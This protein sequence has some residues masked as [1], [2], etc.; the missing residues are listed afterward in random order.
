MT[1]MEMALTIAQKVLEA[2]GQSY[3]VGGYVRDL[4]MGID[5]KD[6]DLEI[7][8]VLPEK[9]AE[10]LDGLGERI[11]IGSS[12]GVYGLKGYGLD[13]AMPRKERATGRGHKD[14]EV[15]VDPFLGTEKAAQRRDF[16][17]NALMR[18]VLTGEIVD[19]FS[20]LSD[21]KE[22]LIRHV[23][24]ETFV[25]DPLRLYRGA[26]FAARFRFRIVPETR[27]LC[28]KMDVSALAGERVFDEMKKALL[29]ADTP[30]V[31]FEEIRKM[32]QLS[33]W[34]PEVGQMIGVEQNPE[35][36]QEGDVWTHTMLV[37]DE[38]ARR[39]ASVRQPL[40][41]MLAAL[42]HDFGK[43]VAT[44]RIDGRLCAYDH[45]H[46]GLPL[47]SSFLNR[48]TSEKQIIDYVMN[49]V[50]L[51]MKPHAMARDNAGIKKTNRMFD[52][53]LE[54]FDL[55]QLAEA[56][57]LSS[58]GTGGPVSEEAFLTERLS[59]FE[60]YMARPYVMGRDLIEAGLEPDKDFHELLEYGHKLRLAGVDKDSALKQ[61]L[62]YGRTKDKDKKEGGSDGKK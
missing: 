1:D 25:E 32:G 29:K 47:A 5:N 28:G 21:L 15:F 35:Y 6:I 44:E 58:H 30:S 54:P 48:L 55:V 16:T 10:I 20:G 26:Q 22:G 40:G 36:H 19:H 41:F 33:V 39:R 50:E 60:E 34:F 52:Q 57:I 46:K 59:V 13:I 7:H 42:C 4:I 24:D 45:E 61:I 17:I 62:A 38:A 12:F 18:N 11:R 53:A 43:I 2:G 37:L 27:E 31:F 49:M 51:H 8:G 14:F 56:D 9:L 3:F 23:N